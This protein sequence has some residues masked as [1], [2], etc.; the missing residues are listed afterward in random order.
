MP[1]TIDFVEA[2][3]E[4]F[5]G[6]AANPRFHLRAVRRHYPVVLH[7]VGLNLLGAAPLDE[8]YL[9]ALARLADELDAPFVSDHLCWTRTATH[10]SFDLL[11][12]PRFEALVDLAAERAAFVQ[13]RLGRPF[14]LENI[15]TSVDLSESTMSEGEFYARVVEQAGVHFMLDVNNLFVSSTNTGFDPHAFLDQID[16]TKVL[17]V[18]VAGHTREAAGNLVDTHDQPLRD[19][20]GSLYRSA[21]QLFGPFPTLLEWDANFPSFGRLVEE[22]QR[23]RAWQ[24]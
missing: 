11:P 17:Q 4:N 19:E 21:W 9:D 22:A 3:S 16:G 15:S 24:R 2:I 10:A 5:L 8:R 7:G 12:A 14:G 23:V 20:V 1:G 18:H 6:D 13:R